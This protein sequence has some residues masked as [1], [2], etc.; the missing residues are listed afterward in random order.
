MPQ[1]WEIIGGGDK[2]GVLVRE[3]EGLKSKSL[4]R[5][6]TGAL[7][8]EITLNGDRLHFKLVEGEGPAE[9]WIAIKLPGKELAV[10]TDKKPGDAAAAAA[11][12]KAA[13]KAA[14]NEAPVRVP[15]PW[16]NVQVPQIEYMEIKD[17]AGKNE[18]GDYYGIKFPHSKDLIME[19]G[20]K[21]LTEAFHKT[22]VLTKDNAV[23][24]I[25]NA[26]EFVGGGAGLKCTFNVEYKKHKPYLH[27]SLFA[28]LPH[29]P[30][31]SDRYYVSCMW[32]HDRPEIIFNIFLETSV[33]FRVPKFYFGDISA[34]TTNCILITEGIPWAKKSVKDFSS[35]K[36]K[37]FEIEPAYDKYKDW[38]LPDGGP[39]YYLACCKALGKMAGMHKQNK[40]HPEIDK[41][42][43]MPGPCHE[44]PRGIPPMDAQS[45]KMQVSK[46]DQLCRFLK[47]TAKAVFPPEITDAKFL[48]DWMAKAQIMC[49]YGNEIGCFCL[50]A[51]AENP[52]DY[53]GLTH[54]NLQIDNA[55]FWRNEDDKVEVGLLDWGVLGCGPLMGAIQ[56]CISGAQ[57]EVLLGHRDNFLRGFIDSYAENGGP[58]LDFERM[59]IM[60]DLMMGNWS[61][62]VSQNVGHVMKNTKA[63]EWPEIKDWM[64]PK[65]LDRFQTRAHCTQFKYSLLLWQKWELFEKFLSF[66]RKV[67]LPEKK[68]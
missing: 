8:E 66:C 33:P 49:E 14:E 54:N 50:G 6:G 57:V 26:K 65:L 29:P 21:W 23:T 34:G 10:K 40:L 67:G 48:D 2:G 43:P 53:V 58:T 63:K 59:V 42:F 61:I 1:L 27:T 18:P 46:L 62:N 32:N 37:P 38:E 51:Y 15:P 52:N 60:N 25:F 7:V 9:G 44:I 56:G 41:M 39:M 11:E 24:N 13:E 28:K 20:P 5:L 55:F 47:D 22:G 12:E 64:D 45:K 16:R 36:F 35:R 19:Y 68:G 31:G 17:R 30:K 4:P 3:G